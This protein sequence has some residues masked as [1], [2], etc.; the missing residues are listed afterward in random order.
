MGLQWSLRGRQVVESCTGPLTKDKIHSRS[1]IQQSREIPFNST[2][3][4]M[5]M[6][7]TVDPTTALADPTQCPHGQPASMSSTL[8]MPIVSP[9]TPAPSPGPTQHTPNPLVRFQP[10]RASY[11]DPASL[12][13]MEF[14]NLAAHGAAARQRYLV[15]L[16]NDCTPSE[17]HFISQ[18]ITPMLKHDFFVELPPELAYHILSFIGDPKTLIRASQVCKRWHN[19]VMDE[20]LWKRMCERYAFSLDIRSPDDDEIA[21][22]PLDSPPFPYQDIPAV[23]SAREQLHHPDLVSTSIRL[24]AV[25]SYHKQ[26]KYAYTLSKFLVT[27]CTRNNNRTIL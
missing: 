11:H 7:E 2:P 8:Y 23:F 4:T 5:A 24:G 1:L 18:T 16:L 21:H 9:P 15:S 27:S 19:L 26:F 6:G 22:E 10:H 17:L 13:R 14:A 20:Y 12:S 25:S 3:S